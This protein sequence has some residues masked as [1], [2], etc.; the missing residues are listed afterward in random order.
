MDPIQRV[1][2]YWHTRSNRPLG[3]IEAAVVNAVLT[4]E[5]VFGP[6]RFDEETITAALLGS[7]AGGLPWVAP[8]VG[9]RAPEESDI[10]WG[11]VAKKGSSEQHA[12]AESTSGAD[13]ALTI[14]I[15]PDRVRL[16][17]FQAKRPKDRATRKPSSSKTRRINRSKRRNSAHFVRR[18]RK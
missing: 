1:L 10:A 6:E 13:F 11:H 12:V 7:L 2:S 9:S 3:P 15:A 5:E 8:A 4:L 18:L 16:G 17:L 14:R